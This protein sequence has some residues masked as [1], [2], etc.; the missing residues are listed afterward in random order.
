MDRNDLSG[1]AGRWRL[2]ANR[3]VMSADR[4]AAPE[5]RLAIAHAYEKL[6]DLADRGPE[7]GMSASG[8][9]PPE[10]KRPQP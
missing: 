3:A 1:I 10:A 6:A 7:L 9:E 8:A 5:A 2:L 4:M